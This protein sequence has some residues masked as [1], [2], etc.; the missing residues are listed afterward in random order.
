M[1]ILLQK[2]KTFVFLRQIKVMRMT[3]LAYIC[4]AQNQLFS[5]GS[6]WC[7]PIELQDP[8]KCNISRNK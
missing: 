7:W 1:D 6:R 2:K 5:S 8:L 4:K 3:I